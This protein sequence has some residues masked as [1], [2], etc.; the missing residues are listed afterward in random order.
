MPVQLRRAAPYAAVGIAGTLLGLLLTTLPGPSASDGARVIGH[1]PRDAAMSTSKAAADAMP[2][3]WGGGGVVLVP[4]S[5]M[6]DTAGTAAGYLFDGSD[7]DTAKLAGTVAR[8][9]GLDGAVARHEDGSASVEV[10]REGSGG[11]AWVS[12]S[13]MFDFSGYNGERGSSGCVKAVPASSSGSGGSGAVE[14]AIPDPCADVK[15]EPTP[16]VTDATALARDAFARLGL[17]LAGAEITTMVSD[18]SVLVQARPLVAGLQM[19]NAWTAQVTAK[20]LSSLSGFAARPV[21]AGTYRTLG[22]A[23][24]VLRSQ[25][26]RWTGFG[27]WQIYSDLAAASTGSA[28]SSSATTSTGSARGDAGVRDGA[29]IVQLRRNEMLVSQPVKTLAQF[30]SLTGQVFLLPAWELRAT[31]G[32]LWSVI[33]ISEDYVEFVDGDVYGVMPMPLGAPRS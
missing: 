5:G 17:N 13:G 21:S 11:S 10:Y 6:P 24:T 8:L 28:A 33:A 23:S 12:G 16:S 20:G 18:G 9:L 30:W 32:S 14:P 19:Q 3:F 2:S 26:L 7:V 1:A 25:R 31:D 4:A 27:P 15:T 22:A 29:R